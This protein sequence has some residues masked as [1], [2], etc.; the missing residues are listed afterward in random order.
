MIFSNYTN[1]EIVASQSDG[2]LAH[3]ALVGIWGWRGPT[4]IPGVT[5]AGPPAFIQSR[6]G[7]RGNFEVVV[8]RAGG[9]LAHLWRNNDS[10]D[11]WAVASAPITT[12]NWSGVGLIH[13]SFGNL[14]IVGVMDGAL[15]FMWQNGAAGPWSRPGIIEAGVRGRPG[16]I[17]S[18]YG[19]GHGNFEVVAARVNGGL[20]HYWR[21]NSDSNGQWSRA[22][23]FNEMVGSPAVYEDVTLIQSS[24]GHLEVLA[25]HTASTLVSHFRA[26]WAAPWQQPNVPWAFTC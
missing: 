4:V 8:P 24:Y 18:T 5:A 20:S 22:V 15:V 6:F 10:G 19:G 9:G 11:T 21:N 26:A 12:G 3:F 23:I 14:E 1:L 25:R 13:S 2:R 16:F 17:Q 7:R